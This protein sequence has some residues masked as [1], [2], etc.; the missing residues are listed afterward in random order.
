MAR[1]FLM[2]LLLA[3]A[4]LSVENYRATNYYRFESYS[5]AYEFYHYYIGTKY[6][7]E[8]GYGEMYAASLIADKETGMKWRHKSG[9]IRDLC[10]GRQV[11]HK[12]FLENAEKYKAKFSPERWEEFKKDISYFKEKLVQYRWNGVLKDKGYNGTPVWSMI[13]GGLLSNRIS[14]DNKVGMTFLALLDPL[15]ILAAFLTVVW[16]FGPRTAFLMI[17][18]LGTHYMMKWWHMKGAYLRTDWAMCLVMAVC[19]I[20]KERFAFAGV[21][22]GYAMLSRIFP[23]VFLFG[24]GAKGFWHLVELSRVEARFVYKRLAIEKRPRE[25]RLVLKLTGIVFFVAFIWGSYGLV[26]DV[27]IPWMGGETKT[28]SIFW[29]HMTDGSGSDSVMMHLFALAA[30]VSVGTVFVI[31]GI[32]ALFERRMNMRYVYFFVA[33]FITV[34][35]LTGLSLLYWQGTENAIVVSSSEAAESG[36]IDRILPGYWKEYKAKIGKHSKDISTWRVGYKYIFMADFGSDFSFVEKAPKDWQPKVRSK[37]YRERQEQW[38][39]VQIWVLLLTLLAASG[40]KDYRAYLLGFAPLFFLV[41]P[42]YY[43]YIMLVIP[44]LFFAP[45]IERGRYAIG[46]ILMYI[47]GMS[48]WIFYDLWKQDYGT[49]YW[50]SVQIMIMVIYMLFLGYIESMEYFLRRRQSACKTSEI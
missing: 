45:Y 22:T 42:T 20:K 15:L 16:A 8:V 4:I 29:T 33:F 37:L 39:R 49:Y 21:L 44:V 38:W 13:V 25:A 24:L 9:S 6:A 27:I 46:M 3:I 36:G 34:A 40:I 23:A 31:V 7:R 41:A 19:C 35:S 12:H 50:L 43:Y 48:G 28:L 2:A 32:R 10:T 17:I 26:N 11:N 5:N 47:T 18:L 1:G 14:T 30:W